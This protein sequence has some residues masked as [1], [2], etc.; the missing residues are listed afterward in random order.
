MKLTLQLLEA[1]LWGA[2]NILRGKTAGQDYKNYILSLMFFKRLCDQWEGEADGS[3][4]QQKQTVEP[5]RKSPLQTSP[6]ALPNQ[7]SKRVSAK[8]G[9][10]LLRHAAAKCRRSVAYYC[11]AA[12]T[13][14]MSLNRLRINS[15]VSWILEG[16]WAWWGLTSRAL[17]S[18][19][20]R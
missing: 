19:P 11:S 15:R 3:S 1:H 4:L 17:R 14:L 9:R 20:S 10:V 12:Y 2:A 5:L 18:S 7:G 16:G 6:A 8:S 13:F